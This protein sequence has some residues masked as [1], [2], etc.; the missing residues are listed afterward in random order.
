MQTAVL[1]LNQLTATIALL[2]VEWLQNETGAAPAR[3][4]NLDPNYSPHGIYQA[5]GTEEWIALT[6]TSDSEF[7]SLC[8]V[9]GREDLAARMPDLDS[10]VSGQR[11][12]DVAIEQWTASQ[13]KWEAAEVLQAHGIPA[14]PV[15]NLRDAMETDPVLPWRHYFNVKQPSNPGVAIP[16]QNTPIQ[17]SGELRNV[18]RAPGYGEDNLYVLQQI[19]GLAPPEIEMLRRDGVVG[20]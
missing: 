2:G 13:D 5:R 7:R 10:R 4:A 1:E 6:A 3:R 17:V 11:E 9:I 14:S 12:L 15:E 19:L 8:Q 18:R 20:P 16:V